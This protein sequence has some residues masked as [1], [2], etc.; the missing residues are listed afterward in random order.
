[1]RLINFCPIFSCSNKRHNFETFRFFLQ[2]LA[3]CLTL[4]NARGRCAWH[5]PIS[6]QLAL[7]IHQIA[8]EYKVS[9]WRH[10]FIYSYDWIQLLDIYKIR[11]KNTNVGPALTYLYLNIIKMFQETTT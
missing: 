9:I 4:P 11:C 10:D 2:Y 6:Q 7:F 1:M 5:K 8:L 3:I